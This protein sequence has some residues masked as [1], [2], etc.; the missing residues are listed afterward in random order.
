MV[1]V[2]DSHELAKRLFMVLNE[3]G[4]QPL[5][6]STFVH[7]LQDAEK[8][9]RMLK[10]SLLDVLDQ[11]RRT[12]EVEVQVKTKNTVEASQLVKTTLQQIDAPESILKKRAV[13]VQVQA[14]R[15]KIPVWKP[16]SLGIIIVSFLAPF[17]SFTQLFLVAPGILSLVSTALGIR[18]KIVYLVF[19]TWAIIG[20]YIVGSI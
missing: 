12:A 1:E 6:F 15:E 10:S 5:G 4:N 7:G 16:V 14:L 13:R 2:I 19:L 17:V 8:L 11:S 3:V 18:R 9:Q 20:L